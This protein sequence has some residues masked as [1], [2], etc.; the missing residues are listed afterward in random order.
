MGA[1]DDISIQV[2]LYPLGDT[3]ITR[4][5]MEFLQI[6]ES[7]DLRYD[8]GSMSTVITGETTAMFRALEEAYRYVAQ[9]NRFVLVCTISNA[10]P[11]E[12]DLGQLTAPE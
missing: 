5:I 7:H 2:S 11:T 4:N 6:F 8:V 12:K 10:V 3:D 9:Q 1:G